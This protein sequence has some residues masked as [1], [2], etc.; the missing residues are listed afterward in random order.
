M[1]S[2]GICETNPRKIKQFYENQ[3]NVDKMKKDLIKNK[4]KE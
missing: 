1:Q 3:T 4:K 2:A